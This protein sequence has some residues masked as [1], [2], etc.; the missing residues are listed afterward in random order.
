METGGENDCA[1][2]PVGKHT[3]PDSNRA[4]SPYPAEI[5][6][7]AYPAQ[8]HGAAGGNHGEFYVTCSAHAIGWDEGKYPGNWLYDRDEAYHEKAQFRAGRFHSGKHGNRFGQC[9]NEQA[10]CDDDCL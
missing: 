3:D 4:E 2:R 7:Q 1:Q 9:K 6:A 10:A 8:P 5:N